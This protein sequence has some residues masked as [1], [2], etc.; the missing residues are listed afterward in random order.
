M[1]NVSYIYDHS[2]GR[3]VLG[4]CLVKLG[5]LSPN[6]YYPLDFSFWFSSRRNDKSGPPVIGDPRSVSGQRSFEAANFTKIELVP[7]MLERA[8]RHNFTADYVLFDS[9]YAWPSLIKTIRKIESGPHVICRLKD[10]KTL[11]TYNGKEYRLSALYQKI[12]SQL[13][14]SKRTGLPIK[15]TTVTMPGSDAPVV[16]VFAKGYGEPEENTIKGK[17]QNPQPKWVAFLSTDTKLHSSTII[18]HYTKRW[19]TEVCFKECKQLLDLGKDHSQHFDAQVFAA[20]LSF[21]RYAVLSYL[22]EAENTS[23]K[24]ILFEH[25]AD[26]AAQITYVQKIWQFFRALFSIS[27][28]K[29]FEL[30]GIEESFQSYFSALEQ[31]IV[32]NTPVL[33]CG[34]RVI[35]YP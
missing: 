10:A 7:Q 19:A 22:N 9:W 32:D 16:I 12:K 5:L 23:S 29:I 25:L 30:F 27:F 21:L 34:T 35:T 13:R 33:G 20:S 1:E 28:S 24:G 18:E 26:E 8:I 4:Y 3:S 15:R 2:R 14:K 31:A 11:Y 6:G 17:K